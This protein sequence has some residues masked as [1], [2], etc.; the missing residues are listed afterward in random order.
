MAAT[1][2]SVNAALE[3][4][5]TQKTLEDQLYSET[6]FLDR[7]KKLSKYT[8]G[9][10]ARVPLHVSRNGGYTALPAG[11]GNLNTA[12]NQGLAKAEFNY[13][14]HH[15]QIA[16]QGDAIDG[17]QGTNAIVEAVDLEV[18]GALTDI[19]RQLTR[20][21]FMNGD[22]LIAQ[23]RTSTTNNVDLNTTTGLHA[24]TRGW[25][26]VGQ[27]V[28]VGTTVAET[29]IVDNSLITAV[30]ETAATPNVTVAA[31]NQAGEGTTHY[32]SQANSRSGTTSYEMNGLQ[33]IVST[34]DLGGLAASSQGTWQ[35]TVNSTSQAISVALLLTAKRVIKQKGG[36][37]RKPFIL[38]GLLQEQKI[39]ESLAQQVRYSSDSKID[40]GNSEKV[41]IA[42]MEIWADPD[43]QDNIAYV[44][45]FDHLFLVAIDKPYWQNKHTGGNI[46]AW[47]QGTDA[48]GAKLSYRVNLATNRRNT[49]YKFTGLV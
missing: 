33:N 39:Y 8:V 43:C 49:L 25:L 11:G 6:P 44:G 17:T 30:D 3:R 15:Q 18:K 10:T 28:D 46:L 7:L 24:V 38:T 42:G 29:A 16:L 34:A 32:V 1:L 26:F 20:Q 27:P 40:A 31:G 13:T 47:V 21:L 37:G 9:E 5:W 2:T 4:V 14:N 35:S 22:A 12:G 41:T 36:G 19:N 23:C 45:D 48:Y